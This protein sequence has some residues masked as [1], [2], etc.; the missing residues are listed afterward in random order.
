MS[1][2]SRCLLAGLLGLVAALIVGCA[3]PGGGGDRAQL[4]DFMRQ[5]RAWAGLTSHALTLADRTSVTYSEGGLPQ[6][7]TLVLL[8]GYTG[9][10]NHWNRVARE[11]TPR[12]HVVVPDLPGH[13][14]TP[15]ADHVSADAMS[16]TMIDFARA[17]GLGDMIIVGHSMGGA[18][19][20]LWALGQPEQTRGLVLIDAAGVYR[21]NPSPVMQAIQRGDNP[22]AIRTEA[23]YQRV[24]DLAMAKPPF[25]P[26]GI[27]RALAM[28]AVAHRDA[29]ARILDNLLNVQ[30]H[31]PASTYQ[32]V[33]DGLRMPALIIWGAKDQIF[34]ARV[35]DE[36]TS[37]LADSRETI[38]DDVGHTPIREAPWRTA[39]A[40]DDFAAS[41]FTAR[42]SPGR[43][44]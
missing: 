26:D 36:L 41:V 3:A 25:I 14:Q 30:A 42:S 24:L 21:D 40:I 11:L 12:W 8:H 44:D 16:N 37:G 34:D 1:N 22:L 13:G 6:A 2:A 38:F 5:E 17:K 9:D 32:M 27:R 39:R 29:Q 31:L 43:R 4:N 23:D 18:V 35:V 19:A 20:T 7:P 33:L 15:L 28:Q 10:R